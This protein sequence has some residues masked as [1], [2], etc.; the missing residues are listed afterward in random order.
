MRMTSEIGVR[1]RTRPVP[2]RRVGDETVVARPEDGKAL[3]LNP[4]A[5]VIWQAMAS[6]SSTDELLGR[7][8][9]VYPAT[10]DATRVE[11]LERLVAEL[12]SEGLVESSRT[13]S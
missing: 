13:T 8:E 5:T 12:L 9:T 4:T 2:L 10:P 3:V 1:Y 6:W 7:L 11:G